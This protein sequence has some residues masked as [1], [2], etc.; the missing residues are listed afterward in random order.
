LVC[1]FF[2][3]D[4]IVVQRC[5]TKIIHVFFCYCIV[6]FFFFFK[7][8]LFFPCTFFFIDSKFRFVS[9]LYIYIYILWLWMTMK[10]G[11]FCQFF[12]QI[13]LTPFILDLESWF[14]NISVDRV[15]TFG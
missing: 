2:L 9:N 13:K 12:C 5:P 4:L 8:Y 10:F 6:S 14:V 3:Y 7:I 15:F 1:F 11:L